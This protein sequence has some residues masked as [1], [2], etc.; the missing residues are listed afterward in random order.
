MLLNIDADRRLERRPP[1]PWT[2][3]L[4][5]GAIAWAS[6]ASTLRLDAA[7]PRPPAPASSPSPALPQAPAARA[8]A[9]GLT[10]AGK[11]ADAETGRP[12]EGAEVLVLVTTPPPFNDHRS[13][14][15]IRQAECT[16][17]AL[18]SF[19]FE[20]PREVAS[21]REN[22]I[23]LRVSH[24]TS[25][26]PLE[27]QWNSIGNVLDDRAGG[28]SGFLDRLRLRPAPTWNL[29]GR[30]VDRVDGRPIAG[31]RARV[32]FA[33]VRDP[34]HPEISGTLFTKLP[35]QEPTTGAD[36]SFRFVVPPAVTVRPE[37][38][39]TIT[40]Q[41]PSSYAYTYIEGDVGS[42]REAQREGRPS[43]VDRLTMER[44]SG[45][46]GQVV[47]PDGRPIARAWVSSYVSEHGDSY[48]GLHSTATDAEGRFR[49]APSGVG[50]RWFISVRA[51]GFAAARR[52]VVEPSGDAGRVVLRPG[53]T[54]RGRLLGPDGL[55]MSG[56]LVEA[57]EA[58]GTQPDFAVVHLS[59]SIGSRGQDHPSHLF[60]GY[61][62]TDA[63]GAFRIANLPPATYDVRPFDP[64]PRFVL[65]GPARPLPKLYI[66]RRVAIA[67]AAD[68]APVELR[69][70]PSVKV[71]ARFFHYATAYTS[72]AS[73]VILRGR[74]G[75]APWHARV[76]FGGQNSAVIEAPKG[77]E[78][79]TLDLLAD[80]A[81]AIRSGRLAG[82]PRE[83]RRP[84]SLGR[85]VALG[86]LVAD[87]RDVWFYRYDAP[88]VLLTVR[89][90]DG[91]PLADLRATASYAGE[92]SKSDPAEVLLSRRP[93]GQFRTVGLVPDEDVALVA[94]ARG[95]RPGSAT[96]RLGEGMVRELVLVLDRE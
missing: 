45:V 82:G 21:R 51:G 53:R 28:R 59:P 68:P 31:A 22:G 48:R 94:T 77:L 11:V 62:T 55:P 67:G 2:L 15:V 54:I 32:G 40:L 56:Y 71:E 9:E 34:D 58:D 3:G 10:F 35:N 85:V 79:A 92:R 6:A 78:D 43:F 14:Q 37:H 52:F 96:L 95:C 46:T 26:A 49:I 47:D 69:P 39:V 30:V 17:D 93:G 80:E 41:H 5:V 86:R 1:R 61:T 89:A 50:D 84:T 74:L 19:R 20:V 60:Y 25:Y 75:E 91:G 90:R 23:R 73:E 33:E 29:V 16:T 83:G 88:V 12:V 27:E 57:A 7:P 38:R 13:Y 87:V 64:D 76:G 18:G 65:P 36:G 8:P 44:A 24:P 63:D 70:V 42:I 4:A 66:P 81:V 72:G